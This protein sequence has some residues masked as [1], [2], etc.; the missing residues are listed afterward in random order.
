MWL[1]STARAELHYFSDPTRVPG[2]YAILS[3][4]WMGQE[5][6]FQDIQAI[7]AN[8]VTSGENPRDHVTPKVRNCCILAERYEHAWV[9]IDSCCINKESSTELSEAIN[10]MFRWYVLSEVCFAYLED[11]PSGENI[12]DEDSA[13]RRARWHTRGWTLQEL[14]APAFLIFV[15]REWEFIGTKAD[16][17]YLIEQI[18]GIQ[19]QYTT[20]QWTFN[21]S[22]TPIA[23]RMSWAANRST[24]RVED[25]AYCLLGLFDLTLPILY[26]EGRRA[27]QRLQEEL[28]KRSSDTTLFVWGTCHLSEGYPATA[29]S[30]QHMQAMG[31]IGSDVFAF[32]PCPRAFAV[33]HK[34]VICTP[35][36][37]KGPNFQPYMP[38]Q[39]PSEVRRPLV[40]PSAK[41]DHFPYEGDKR[42]R[43]TT[44]GNRPIWGCRAPNIRSHQP[45]A[46]VSFPY[47]GSRRDHHRGCSLT[48]LSNRQCPWPASRAPALFLTPRRYIPRSC[49]EDVLR[50]MD[51]R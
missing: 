8:C 27:F 9:W 13:F 5:Q 10:S 35:M 42:K 19:A 12:Y 44:A 15:S 4:T 46:E 7:R 20:R 30:P 11:V 24:T 18:T 41:S 25:E 26:G 31:F 16:D 28:A 36:L 43:K 50:L 49:S 14:L 32:A 47:S 37:G 23:R 45:W 51:I 17:A 48:D 34:D 21:E 29:A 38:H 39:W 2:G 6:T 33:K 1:L 3:H 40:P 22:N